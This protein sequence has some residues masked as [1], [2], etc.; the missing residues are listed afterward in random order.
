MYHHTLTSASIMLHNE[1]FPGACP[2]ETSLLLKAPSCSLLM[3]AAGAMQTVPIKVIQAIRRAY[4]GLR[5]DTSLVVVDFLP[6]NLATFPE[7]CGKVKKK[8][9][10]GGMACFCMARQAGDPSCYHETG[11]CCRLHSD[12]SLSN[13]PISNCLACRYA[14][15]MH[16]LIAN[17][18]SK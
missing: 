9:S 3:P 14:C 16:C 12:C 6:D 4:G 10:S 1:N 11:G 7:L 5:D 15:T 13:F 18:I 8:S 2:T 17:C